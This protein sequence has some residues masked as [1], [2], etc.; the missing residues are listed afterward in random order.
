[1]TDAAG[2]AG[3][4]ITDRPNPFG[5]GCC[6]S[7]RLAGG[8]GCGGVGCPTRPPW[9][10]RPPGTPG[11]AG[12]RE[13]GR[14]HLSSPGWPPAGHRAGRRQ[15]PHPA[16]PRARQTSGRPL[17]PADQR[18][19]HGSSAS[20]NPPGGDR[21]E[22][23]AAHRARTAAVGAA[24]GLRWHLEPGGRR[25]RLRRP[26][27]PGRPDAG[28]RV[29][30]G[31]PIPAPTPARIGG[32]VPAPGDHPG[33]RHRAARG[34]RRS[35]ATPSA[36]RRLF[37]GLAEAP[38]RIRKAPRRCTRWRPPATTSEPPSPGSSP[39]EPTTSCCSSP[40]RSAGTGPPGTTRKAS[41]LCRRSWTRSTGRLRSVRSGL[42]A[43]AYVESICN[44]AL[45][46]GR[47]GAP[48]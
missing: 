45:L 24:V 23:R 26:A 8:C 48:R 19:T 7:W 36:P 47:A 38:A 12:A 25:S 1:M 9:R 13:A 20:T 31:R 21:L 10:P 39:A 16:D 17:P 18:G 2:Q 5:V 3:Q 11:C 30:A 28:A 27:G 43:S 6:G 15:D 46:F 29:P 14:R 42:L 22:L 33:L 34:P 37:L 32:A 4:F 35:T 41:K 40:G 44:L